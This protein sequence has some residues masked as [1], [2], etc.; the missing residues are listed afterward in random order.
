M[1]GAAKNSTLFRVESNSL[2]YM[3][4]WH[5]YSPLPASRIRQPTSVAEDDI[6]SRNTGST[7]EGLLP[8]LSYKGHGEVS[9][10]PARTFGGQT[11]W[12]TPLRF[13]WKRKWW[14]QTWDLEGRAVRH[15]L[16]KKGLVWKKGLILKCTNARKDGCCFLPRHFFYYEGVCIAIKAS[17]LF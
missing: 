1:A 3:F 2:L 16:R 10:Y 15:V 7:R 17:T 6:H 5:M 4:G 14:W 11:R 9:R 8:P 13:Q 12:S